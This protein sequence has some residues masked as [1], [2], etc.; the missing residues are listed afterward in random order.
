MTRGH[1]T[2]GYAPAPSPRDAPAPAPDRAGAVSPT[3]DPGARRWRVWGTSATVVVQSPGLADRAGEIV[4]GEIAAMDRACSRFRPDSDLARV[5]RGDGR[6]VRVGPLAVEAIGAALL[7]A[8]RTGGAVDPT[9]GGAMALLGYDRDFDEVAAAPCSQALAGVPVPVPGWRS[10]EV[11]EEE[12]TLRVPPGVQLDLGATA[13]ALCADRAAAAVA[14]EL[15]VGAAVGLGGD[16]AFA[17]TS[18]A[19]GWSVAVMED[20]RSGALADDCVVAVTGGGLASSGTTLRTWRRAGH[21]LHHIVDPTT[22]WPA[23]PVWRLVTVAARSCAE[24]NAA[25]TASVVWGEDAPFRLAQMGL[26]A[27]L[28]HRD[29]SV[30]VVGGWPPASASTSSGAPS[31]SGR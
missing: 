8:A 7:A 18:P 12:R 16:V 29:R 4:R 17:G 21:P 22:G 1:S 30:T 14:R 28:V 25:S 3:R 31:G 11:D 6:P 23:D 27:R 19:D 15:G 24:A 10:V 13:K 5:N 20:G 26:A 9:V 2:A